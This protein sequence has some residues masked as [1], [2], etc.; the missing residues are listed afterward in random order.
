M[1]WDQV[2]SLFEFI[3]VI[4]RAPQY[5][6]HDVNAPVNRRDWRSS[7][8]NHD[9]TLHFWYE[10]VGGVAFDWL[11]ISTDGGNRL[12]A[13]SGYGQTIALHSITS[14]NPEVVINSFELDGPNARAGL[15]APLGGLGAAPFSFDNQTYNGTP[16]AGTQA[17]DPT[18]PNITLTGTITG[19]GSFTLD[20]GNVTG[21]WW[22][23]IAQLAPTVGTATL[24]LKNGT[25][26]ENITISN[27]TS[28][29]ILVRTRPNVVAANPKQ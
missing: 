20:F 10:P 28:R 24:A 4:P 16:L 29:L 7:D 6:W 21:N 26:T 22:I 23:D 25:D 1:A 17:V 3:S 5:Q 12:S 13:W 27:A 15:D 11:T 18:K 19:G 14:G 9:G 2:N 8:V